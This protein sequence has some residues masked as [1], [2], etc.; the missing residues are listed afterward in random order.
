MRA[1][2]RLNISQDKTLTWA[3]QTGIEVHTVNLKE[4]EREKKMKPQNGGQNNLM[5]S[6]SK[7]CE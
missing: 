3:R 6:Q 7:K 4:R 2:L 1:D 5:S